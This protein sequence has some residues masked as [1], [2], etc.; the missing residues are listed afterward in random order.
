M[1]LLR[2]AWG[3]TLLPKPGQNRSFTGSSSEINSIRSSSMRQ[4]EFMKTQNVVETVR[5]AESER[6][7]PRRIHPVADEDYARCPICNFDL[8]VFGTEEAAQQEHVAACIRQAEIAQQQHSIVGSP[9][10]QNRMLVY[11]IPQNSTNIQECPIC[12]EDMLPGQKVGRLECLCVFHYHC[13]KSWFKKKVQKL[14]TLN[15]RAEDT[16][17]MLGKNYCPFHDAVYY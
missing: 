4:F 11:Q 2:T 16:V 5:E 9:T 7:S 8:Q 14:S 3:E 1:K 15:P 10:Y 12:F 13:I 17:S 6:N